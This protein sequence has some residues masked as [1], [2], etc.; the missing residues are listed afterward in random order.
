MPSAASQRTPSVEDIEMESPRRALRLQRTRRSAAWE[1]KL[2]GRPTLFSSW[3]SYMATASR[4]VGRFHGQFRLGHFEYMHPVRLQGKTPRRFRRLYSVKVAYT[5]WGTHDAPTIICCGGVTNTAMRFNYL[6]ADLSGAFR[7]VC[8]DWV[9]RGLSGWMADEHDYSLQTC[10]EQLRQMIEHVGGAP[11]TVLGSSLGGSA[12]IALA[13]RYPKLVS[14]LILNDIGPYMPKSRRK[15]RSETLARHYVF[16]DPA[17]LLRRIGACQKNDGPISNDIR[18]S[19]TFHQTRWCAVEGARIYRH[20]PRAMQ[21]YRRDARE[22]LDQWQEWDRLRVPVLLIHGLQSDALTQP[23]IDRMVR[24]NSVRVMHVPD[25]G[26]T[27]VL[28]DRNQIWFIQQWLR[29]NREVSGE[30]TIL[31]APSRETFPGSPVPF[32]SARSLA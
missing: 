12:G 19:L 17:D 29:E 5:D 27:P 9:G 11:V 14:R 32:A 16:R 24:T 8:M 23:T 20:D 28:A 6:A 15:R 7:V 25:T 4:I 26:H 22:A 30:L 13:A 18:F 10:S 21:A 2:P 3:D 1:P 31:H